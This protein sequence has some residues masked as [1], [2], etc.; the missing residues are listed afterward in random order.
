LFSP[1]LTALDQ[2]KNILWRSALASKSPRDMQLFREVKNQYTQVV[3]KAKASFFK[4][5][6]VSCST[7]SKKFRDTVKSMENKS[8]S[9]QV[10]TALMLGNT[11]TTDKLRISI[12][13]FPPGWPYPRQQPCTHHSSSPKPPPFSSPKSR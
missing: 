2:H 10:P 4:Q 8:T 1:D 11:I 6:C 3:R 5:K 12:S 7:N 9:S 13:I